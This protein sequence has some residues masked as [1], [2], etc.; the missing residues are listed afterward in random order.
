MPTDI[1]T[2]STA[3]YW[4]GWVI[5]G[6]VSL[7]F[8]F[9]AIAKILAV[10]PVVEASAKLGLP[11]STT[12]PIGILLLVCMVIYL[13]PQTSTIGAILLAG[14]LGGAIAIHIR[15]EGGLFPVV[16]AAAFGILVWLGLVLREPKVWSAVWMR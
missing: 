4:T 2:V 7:F 3:A 16:F 9:D 6:L 11:S 10:A 12:L 14:Y 1:P 5:T 8:S 15:A 13:V